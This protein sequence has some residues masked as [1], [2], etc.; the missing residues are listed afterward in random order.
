MAA[1]SYRPV[2]RGKIEL[3]QSVRALFEGQSLEGILHLL[4]DDR[5]GTSRESKFV[6]GACWI[7]PIVRFAGEEARG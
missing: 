3:K 2:P 1:F 5:G 7:A 6:R 4:T